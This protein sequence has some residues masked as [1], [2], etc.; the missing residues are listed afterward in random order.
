MR[1]RFR[2][3]RAVDFEKLRRRGRRW[4]HPLI[5]LI[6]TANDANNSRFGFSASKHF[7]NAA[8]RNRAKRMM[9][10]VV[11]RN[12]DLIEDGW[13]CLFVARGTANGAAFPE[14]EDAIYKLLGRAELIK[15]NPIMQFPNMREE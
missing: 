7:G 12:L 1:K 9:R 5:M 6:T 13:D 11:R 14:I 2:L 4:H 3:R 10:E 15:A 8:A